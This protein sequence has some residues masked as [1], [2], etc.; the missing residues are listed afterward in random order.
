MNCLEDIK[1]KNCLSFSVS[2]A[3]VTLQVEH[4]CK[5]KNDKV[6]AHQQL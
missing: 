3:D 6:N 1:V 5:M 4:H 2:T